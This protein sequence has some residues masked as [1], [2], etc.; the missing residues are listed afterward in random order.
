[1]RA[2]VKVGEVAGP[3]LGPSAAAQSGLRWL[4]RRPVPAVSPP[5]LP[6]TVTTPADVEAE[7]CSLRD[8]SRAWR[9]TSKAEKVR[10]LGEVKS[11][12]LKRPQEW[13]RVATG[14]QGQDGCDAR[15]GLMMLGTV[16]GTSGY[17]DGLIR[18]HRDDSRM[19]RPKS[20]RASPS[21][22]RQVAVVPNPLEAT[23]LEVE[24]WMQPGKAIEQ[25]GPAECAWAS[26]E[27]AALGEEGGVSVVLGAGNVGFLSL[28]DVLHKLFV[29]GECVLLKH[30]PVQADYGRYMEECLAPLRDYG[31]YRGML[32]DPV[33]VR[34]AMQSPN[35]TSAHI[36]GGT[37]TYEGLLW[38]FDQGEAAERRASN[39]PLFAKPF[40]SELG[41]VTPWVMAPPATEAGWDEGEMRHVAQCLVEATNFNVSQNCLSPKVVMVAEEW[42]Q[43]DEFIAACEGEFAEYPLMP[44][45]Y[46]GIRERYEAWCDFYRGLEADGGRARFSQHGEAV[47]TPFQSACSEAVSAAQ[48][49]PLPWAVAVRNLADVEDPRAERGFAVEPFSPVLLFVKVPS[50]VLGIQNGQTDGESLSRAFLKW[51]PG[52]CNANLFGTLSCALWVDPRTQK[53]LGDGSAVEEAIENLEYGTVMLNGFGAVGYAQPN[54]VWGAFNRG[55]T[56]TTMRASDSGVGFIHNAF[57]FVAPEKQVVRA[58]FSK[59]A[60]HMVPPHRGP[61]I[62]PP[63]ARFLSGLLGGGFLPAIRLLFAG[64]DDKAAK[65]YEP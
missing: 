16:A 1:M 38:G 11:L 46:P 50:S 48:G 14:V 13:A 56:A 35:V 58:S 18:A 26:E 39:T 60:S 44:A 41:C 37:A 57:G 22:T 64:G 40:T 36:T 21:G 52:Y 63:L 62:A 61:K 47:K 29:D 33:T 9:L 54:G 49:P 4:P 25:R 19:P 43:V 28:H 42:A 30:H 10:L 23:G 34:A 2:A 8:R 53:A 55:Q 20:T 45:Y 17:I 59:S 15:M 65:T 32:C 27:S 6:M 5:P 51:A 24:V 31:V 3:A 12:L 7:L